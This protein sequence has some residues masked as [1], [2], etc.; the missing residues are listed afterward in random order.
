[1]Q[2]GHKKVE[3][4]ETNIYILF[5]TNKTE[6]ALHRH[7]GI[8]EYRIRR[9]TLITFESCSNVLYCNRIA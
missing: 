6:D 4:I 8:A 7:K 5:Y 9:K 3:K 1:M 2:I